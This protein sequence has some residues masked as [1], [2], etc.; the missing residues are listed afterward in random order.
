M[1]SSGTT[2]ATPAQGTL[3]SGGVVAAT[4]GPAAVTVP[5]QT[6]DQ[7]LRAH[8]LRSRW[9]TFRAPKAD[10]D[11]LEMCI[12][13]FRAQLTLRS[14]EFLC[15]RSIAGDDRLQ[16]MALELFVTSLPQQKRPVFHR[17]VTFT[18]A[19]KAFVE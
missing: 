17:Y 13:G 19:W 16:V 18:D 14:A 4:T 8:K 7:S 12:W 5:L 1:S 6:D 9:N 11:D 3:A 15:E 2:P 10:F